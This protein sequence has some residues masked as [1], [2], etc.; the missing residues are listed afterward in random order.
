METSDEKEFI[1]IGPVPN[2]EP[3]TQAGQNSSDSIFECAVY[4]RQLIRTYGDPPQGCEFFIM[5]NHHDFGTYYDVNLFFKVPID[6]EEENYL[7]SSTT[8]YEHTAEEKLFR[9]ND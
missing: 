3:C 8:I 2:E 5:R 4:I 9:L 7:P 1:N 6:K